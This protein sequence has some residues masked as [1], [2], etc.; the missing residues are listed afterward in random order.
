M[1]NAHTY[2]YY[3]RWATAN[4]FPVDH[5]INDGTTIHRLG[6]MGDL[7]LARPRTLPGW[8]V[9]GSCAPGAAGE[10]WPRECAPLSAARATRRCAQV[11]RS[12]GIDD[13]ICVIAGDMAFYPDSFDLKGFVSFFESQARAR[14]LVPLSLP[15]VWASSSH[16]EQPPTRRA[17]IAAAR[18]G[19]S[20]SHAIT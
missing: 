14:A 16:T 9:A 8:R 15:S 4:E 6:A 20:S 19:A 18:R 5:I 17:S 7:A 11:L 10:G 13:D 2:K 3:E 12:Q 1:T